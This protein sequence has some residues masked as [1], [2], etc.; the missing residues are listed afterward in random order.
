MTCAARTVP[1][2]SL[3]ALVLVS[4]QLLAAEGDLCAANVDCGDG[5]V[6]NLPPT[7]GGS[8][9]SGG[10]AGAATEDVTVTGS[11]GV[12]PVTCTTDADCGEHFACSFDDGSTSA[13]CDAAGNC[14]AVE[15]VATVGEC[16]GVPME[17]AAD[18][19][20]PEASV[21]LEGLCTYAPTSCTDDAVCADGYACADIGGEEGACMSMPCIP[22]ATGTCVNEVVCETTAAPSYCFPKPVACAS[23]ADCPTGWSCYGVAEADLEGWSDLPLACLPPGIVGAIEGWVTVEGESDSA[24]SDDAGTVAETTESAGPGTNGAADDEGGGCSVTGARASGRGA[25]GLLLAALALVL[26]RRRAR[27]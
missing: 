13:G 27:F 8:S 2:S 4:P 15:D 14:T 24:G 20:C 22:D 5:Y 17:C 9:G 23:D 26:G 21:C 1:F 3:L 18:A 11:C 16:V 19:D 10:S 25:L 12:A 6:C 7:A